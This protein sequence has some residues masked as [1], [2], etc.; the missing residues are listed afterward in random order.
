MGRLDAEQA[1]LLVKKTV[2]IVTKCSITVLFSS[3][4]NEGRKIRILFWSTAARVELRSR[5]QTY[6]YFKDT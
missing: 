6:L 5:K 1:Q 3:V 2:G 4:E